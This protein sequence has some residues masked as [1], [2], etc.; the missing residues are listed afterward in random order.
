MPT[1]GAPPNMEGLIQRLFKWHQNGN[2]PVDRLIYLDT[3]HILKAWYQEHFQRNNRWNKSMIYNEAIKMNADQLNRMS[4]CFTYLFD[5]EKKYNQV[6]LKHCQQILEDRMP[7]TEPHIQKI[8]ISQK[9]YLELLRL[10]GEWK[11]T[12]EIKGTYKELSEVIYEVFSP[13]YPIK[14]STIIDR[15]KDQKGYK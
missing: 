9:A 15:L 8:R 5:P 14:P 6:F 3:I 13:E 4:V 1:K 2:F 7:T 11:T 12:K 10:V